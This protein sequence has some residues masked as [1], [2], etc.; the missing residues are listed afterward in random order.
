MKRLLEVISL[1]CCV[2]HVTA[3]ELDPEFTFVNFLSKSP[4]KIYLGAIMDINTLNKDTHPVLA[5]PNR[6]KI[7]V[8]QE[9][10]IKDIQILPNKE[11]MNNFILNAPLIAK[12]LLLLAMLFIIGSVVQFRTQ[13][14][15]N[16]TA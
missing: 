14:K 5:I 10:P 15:I 8:L 1:L 7:N 9:G 13:R 16:K 6:Q 11:N 12:T 4:D 2:M 3:Q